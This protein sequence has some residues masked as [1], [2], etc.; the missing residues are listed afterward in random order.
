[1]KTKIRR[2]RFNRLVNLGKM[3]DLIVERYDRT[4]EVTKNYTTGEV[5]TVCKNLDQVESAILEHIDD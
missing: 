5:T 3:C 4:Y 1:M 2:S